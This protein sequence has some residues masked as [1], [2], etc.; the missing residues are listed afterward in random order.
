[1]GGR[2]IRVCDAGGRSLSGHL[3]VFPLVIGFLRDRP[4]SFSNYATRTEEYVRDAT[5][6]QRWR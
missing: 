5:G 4:F 6:G 3:V 2:W 1:M